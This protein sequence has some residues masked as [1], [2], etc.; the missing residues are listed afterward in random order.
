MFW[1]TKALP[2]ATGRAVRRWKELRK[3]GD[4]GCRAVEEAAEDGLAMLAAGPLAPQ[5]AV[6]EKAQVHA[7]LERSVF[8]T[9]HERPCGGVDIALVLESTGRFEVLK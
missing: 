6:H 7:A 1:Y 8:L 3:L 4:D 2:R 5:K 9:C